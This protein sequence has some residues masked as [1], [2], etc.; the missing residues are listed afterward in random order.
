M[1]TRIIVW[2]LLL[3]ITPSLA[4]E[5][6][7]RKLTTAKHNNVL[8]YDPLR[9]ICGEVRF[10]YERRLLPN[11]SL[12]VDGGVTS[13]ESGK[14]YMIYYPYPTTH[15]DLTRSDKGVIASIALRF[16]P[17]TPDRSIGGMYISP[18]FDW[19]TCNFSGTYNG[20]D[21]ADHTDYRYTFSTMFFNV[22]W[23]AWYTEHFCIDYYLGVGY[24]RVYDQQ[25]I[26]Y[27]YIN[28]ESTQV[29]KESRGQYFTLNAGIKI[30]LGWNFHL[31]K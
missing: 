28:K 18:E 16:Y 26:S 14:R 3:K 27:Q 21:V 4:Q 17:L 5:A 29:H 31:P 20:G 30:G 22:G 1:K 15:S 8:K 19:K 12:E 7:V 11:L 10:S 25:D 23:Q 9:L 24:R 13:S 6:E 2:M